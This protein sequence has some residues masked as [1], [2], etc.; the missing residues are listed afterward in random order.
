MI[1]IIPA[2]GK[3]TR[4]AEVTQGKSKEL[5]PLGSRTVVDRILDEAIAAG[6]AGVM[7]VNHPDKHDMDTWV[8]DHQSVSLAYQREQLG[9]AHAIACASA[10][11]D[12]LIQLGDTVYWGGSPATRLVDSLALADGAIAVEPISDAEV[13][14]YGIVEFDSDGV[15]TRILEKPTVDETQSRWA[16]AARYVLSGEL[17]QLLPEWLEPILQN[18]KKEVALTPFLN[19]CIHAGHRLVAVPLLA[20]EQRTDCGSPEEYREALLKKWD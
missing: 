3:G 15:I 7:L 1:A 13:H 12:V 16:V 10:A 19:H 8:R 18:S 20:N 9:L 2:A 4:M 17:M 14:L 6:A 11:E 5:L